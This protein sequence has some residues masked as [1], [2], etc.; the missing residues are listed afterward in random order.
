VGKVTRGQGERQ[1][2]KDTGAQRSRGHTDRCRGREAGI[3]NADAKIQGGVGQDRR[4]FKSVN[5][6]YLNTL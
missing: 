4:E 6:N 5:Y 1:R 3:Q 2:G